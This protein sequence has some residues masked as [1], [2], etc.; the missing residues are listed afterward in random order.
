MAKSLKPIVSETLTDANDC[1][2][3]RIKKAIDTWKDLYHQ[4]EK[5]LKTLIQVEN[6][7]E[8]CV[9]DIK[10]WRSIPYASYCVTKVSFFFNQLK[11]HENLKAKKK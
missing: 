10:N 1:V 5:S 6:D 3:S 8:E 9:K 4:A 11:N 7:V 2:E